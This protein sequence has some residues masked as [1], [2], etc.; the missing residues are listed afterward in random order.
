M[1]ERTV[2]AIEET[3]ILKVLLLGMKETEF[4]QIQMNCGACVKLLL[5][6]DR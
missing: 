5:Q 4:P 2:I 6:L 3:D 1:T